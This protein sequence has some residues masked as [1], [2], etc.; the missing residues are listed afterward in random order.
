M[1]RSLHS[2]PFFIKEQND[3]CVL[4]R[5]LSMNGTFFLVS[6]VIQKFQILQKKNLKE[7]SVFFIRFKKNF[8][9]FFQ[10]IFIYIYISIYI[11]IYLYIYFYMYLYIYC[12]RL[13][14]KPVKELNSTSLTLLRGGSDLAAYGWREKRLDLSPREVNYLS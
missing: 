7:R 8:P 6:L 12:K 9:F 13:P 2:F 11:F 4:L 5:W 14:F 1:E 10:Y 3:L